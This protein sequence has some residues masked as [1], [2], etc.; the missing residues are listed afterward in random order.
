MICWLSF[1]T[2]LLLFNYV[3]VNI[4]IIHCLKMYNCCVCKK[5][6]TKETKFM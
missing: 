1:F 2:V 5:C 3:A 6:V 4:K